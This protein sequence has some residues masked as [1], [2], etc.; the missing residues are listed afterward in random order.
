MESPNTSEGSAFRGQMTIVLPLIVIVCG[1]LLTLLMSLLVQRP[2][3]DHI[4]A[5]SVA[6]H[7]ALYEPLT[8]QVARLLADTRHLS[9]QSPASLPLAVEHFLALHPRVTGIEYLETVNETQ[10][11]AVEHQFSHETGQFIRFDTW[12]NAVAEPREE[13]LIIRSAVYQPGAA[14]PSVALGLVAD[15]VPHWQSALYRA[16]ETGRVSATTLTSLQRNGAAQRAVRLF[17]PL[18]ENRLISLVIDPRSWLS[19]LLDPLHDDRWEITLHDSSQHASPPLF[20][21]PTLGPAA[22]QEA[23]RSTF[24][25]ADRQWMLTTLPSRTWMDDLSREASL[26]LWLLGTIL[27]L[28]AAVLTGWLAYRVTTSRSQAF[29]DQRHTGRARR[30]SAN[31]K[32]EKSILHQ[33]LLDSEARSRDLIELYGGIVCEL[34]GQGHLVYLSPQTTRLLGYPVAELLEQPL[35][36]LVTPADHLRLNEALAAAR[37]ENRVQR[38]DLSLIAGPDSLPVTLRVKALRPRGD[39]HTG[40]RLTLLPR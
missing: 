35:S 7:Q 26:P 12:R 28:A 30:Q 13:Y 22:E 24:S 11:A 32:I 34:D 19:G 33:S 29:A 4:R 20:S 8:R 38:S 25:L 3:A 1:L 6:H 31:L 2:T 40:Y 39:G 16:R 37:R 36:A 27:S 5:L 21:L 9:E 18:A 17:V 23:I 15:S 14:D 10:R